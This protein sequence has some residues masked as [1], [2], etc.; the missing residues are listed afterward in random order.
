MKK[1]CMSPVVRNAPQRLCKFTHLGMVESYESSTYKIKPDLRVIYAIKP[2]MI[3][4]SRKVSA[5]RIWPFKSSSM[6]VLENFR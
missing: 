3:A 2:I 6:R 4:F 1:L 5:S